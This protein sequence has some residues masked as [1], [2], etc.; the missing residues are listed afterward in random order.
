MGRFDFVVV[1]A[2]PAIPRRRIDWRSRG[3]VTCIFLVCGIWRG[4]LFQFLSRLVYSGWSGFSRREGVSTYRLSRSLSCESNSAGKSRNIQSICN[5]NGESMYP[6][7]GLDCFPDSEAKYKARVPYQVGSQTRDG[8]RRPEG[9]ECDR[10][11]RAAT[12]VRLFR[13]LLRSSQV[14]GYPGTREEKGS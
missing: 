10:W 8:S 4:Q 3:V 14:T 13:T 1:G 5:I 9:L 11:R 12:G 6:G 2:A 7:T